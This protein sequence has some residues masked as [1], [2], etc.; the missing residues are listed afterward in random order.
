MLIL[1]ATCKSR[2]AATSLIKTPLHKKPTKQL[3]PHNHS[4]QQYLLM[5]L[6]LVHY[7]PL[8]NSYESVHLCSR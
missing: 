5:Y 2:L 4:K 6:A 7:K 1:A 8:L 3:F